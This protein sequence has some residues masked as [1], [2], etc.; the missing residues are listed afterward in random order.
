MRTVV[1]LG[2]VAGLASPVCEK[3]RLHA[4]LDP[5]LCRLV[6]AHQPAPDVAYK[7]GVDVHGKPVVEADLNPSPIEAPEKI[8]FL[9]TVDVAKYIG[10]KQV[11]QGV[12]GHAAVAA[13][14]YE[15]GVL[16]INGAP[17]EGAA[18]SALRELCAAG[19]GAEKPKKGQ[20]DKHNQ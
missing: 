17:A 2:M 9:I 11:P 15:N 18:V 10:L 20:K 14:A 4:E 8:T 5:G 6:V 1:I 16:T 12:E 13:V 19:N 7:P 3:H